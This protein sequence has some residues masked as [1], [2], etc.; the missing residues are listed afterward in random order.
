MTLWSSLMSCSPIL[1]SG[2]R[3]R[4]PLVRPGAVRPLDPPLE[5][6]GYRG[7]STMSIHM[8]RGTANC[9]RLW[10]SPP[11][12]HEPRASHGASPRPPPGTGA[13]LR[14]GKCTLYQTI[15][16]MSSLG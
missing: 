3:P 12:P 10:A 14:A 7:P 15:R 2:P 13:V 5:S 16:V 8:D 9:D 11:S 6:T 1:E 4:S